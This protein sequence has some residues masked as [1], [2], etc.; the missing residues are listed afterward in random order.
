M[1]CRGPAVVVKVRVLVCA[2]VW[3]C[4]LVTLPLC[5]TYGSLLF[6]TPLCVQRGCDPCGQ[7]APASLGLWLPGDQRAG[8][9]GIWNGAPTLKDTWLYLAPATTT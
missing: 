8:G 2:S 3:R 6:S 9:A 1:G 4:G 7:H 5:L